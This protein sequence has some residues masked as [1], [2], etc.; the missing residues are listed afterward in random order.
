MLV[1]DRFGNL[2][3]NVTREHIDE[4]GAE[5]GDRVELRFHLDPYYAVVAETYEQANRGELML[6]EDSYGAFSIAISGGDASN[7]TGAGPGDDVRIGRA[8]D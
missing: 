4:F 3:L 1:V 2:Q 7:L 5:P 8:Y 6:Y